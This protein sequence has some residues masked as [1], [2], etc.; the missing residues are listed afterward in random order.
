MD[1][2]DHDSV[3]FLFDGLVYGVRRPL[4]HPAIQMTKAWKFPPTDRFTSS[5]ENVVSLQSR[6]RFE[7]IVVCARKRKDRDPTESLKILFGHQR[8]VIIV[9]HSLTSP[10]AGQVL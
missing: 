9:K 3:H 7:R 2:L 8:A 1:L 5:F 4:A 6:A 10:T